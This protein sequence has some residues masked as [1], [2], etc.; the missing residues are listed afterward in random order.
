MSCLKKASGT[1]L[2]VQWFG[3]HTATVGDI[4]SI[5]GQGTKI[6]HATW[7]SQKCN[8]N[9]IKKAGATHC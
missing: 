8:N 2:V 3:F 5:P 1:S 4:G 6:L 7:H 9:N